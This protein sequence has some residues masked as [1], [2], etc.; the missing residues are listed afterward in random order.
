MSQPQE[1]KYIDGVLHQLV[2]RTKGG[3]SAPAWEPV[4]SETTKQAEST[5]ESTGSKKNK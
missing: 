2:M 5:V 1:L 3:V 4:P